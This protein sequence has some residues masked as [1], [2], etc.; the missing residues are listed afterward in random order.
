MRKIVLAGLLACLFAV[1]AS[2]PSN[3]A[4]SEAF[5]RNL[6]QGAQAAERSAI[7][8]RRASRSNSIARM[9]SACAPATR[10]YMRLDRAARR[11][12]SCF[13]VNR[14][15]RR[16]LAELRTNREAVRFF[17]RGCGF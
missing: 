13:N 14:Q 8:C 16:L 5:Y 3:A 10:F 2:T 9:C 4:C 17:N 6:L 15:G 7:A 1:P 11:N 12:P